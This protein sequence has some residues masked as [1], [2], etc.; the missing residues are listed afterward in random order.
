[1]IALGITF[2]RGETGSRFS[3]GRAAGF[4]A[5]GACGLAEKVL[6]LD[7]P[8]IIHSP[9]RA[10]VVRM[11]RSFALP[12]RG[13]NEFERTGGRLAAWVVAGVRIGRLD[14]GID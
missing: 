5:S 12:T 1:L 14:R 10:V 11:G 7:E 6:L 2:F 3:V 13:P 9:E 8:Q 4:A